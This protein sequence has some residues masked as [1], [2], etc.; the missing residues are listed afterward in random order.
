MRHLTGILIIV[1]ALAC[2]KENEP[3][4]QALDITGNCIFYEN[5]LS[6]CF[7]GSIPPEFDE[8]VFSSNEVYR[9]FGDSIRI[10]PVNLDCDTAQLP[11]IDFNHYDLLTKKTSGS[12]CGASYSREVIKDDNNKTINYNIQVTY[13]GMCE[14]LIISR[15]WVLVPKIPDGYTVNF[16]V[17]EILE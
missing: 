6:N 2:D 15:N 5:I 17:E 12:G 14:K 7:Y 8:Y 9:Q 11:E 10:Y 4:K 13:N 1:I 16:K 3:T